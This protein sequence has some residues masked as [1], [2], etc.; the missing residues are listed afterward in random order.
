MLSFFSGT[1]FGSKLC[2]LAGRNE[3]HERE[4]MNSQYSPIAE[5]VRLLMQWKKTRNL[6]LQVKSIDWCCSDI[7]LFSFVY[8][9]LLQ[10]VQDIKQ[11]DP[12]YS[13]KKHKVFNLVKKGKLWHFHMPIHNG[14]SYES[15][16]KK[17][18]RLILDVKWHLLLL[19]ICFLLFLI[20][21]KYTLFSRFVFSYWQQKIK[22]F[23]F[24]VP[25]VIC[26]A[27]F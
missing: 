9:M 5:S 1:L 11:N 21:A 27:I 8:S 7:F 6:Y 4:K 3:L 18:K 20:N 12:I 24:L 16:H 10:K 26:R 19:S 17:E 13:Q 14:N 15:Y 22:L 2:K 25:L 23:F